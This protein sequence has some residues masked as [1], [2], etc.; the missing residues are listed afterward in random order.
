M[1]EEERWGEKYIGV[2][3]VERKAK[4][5]EMEPACACTT[6]FIILLPKS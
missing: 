4:E 6:I 2:D 5:R 1:K 3:A